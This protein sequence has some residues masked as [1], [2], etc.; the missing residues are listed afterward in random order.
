MGRLA[1]AARRIARAGRGGQRGVRV[2]VTYF[3]RCLAMMRGGGETQHLAWMRA[4]RSLGVEIDIITGRPLLQPPLYP[5]DD[6]PT[7]CCARRTCAIS[8]TKCRAS[9]SSAASAIAWRFT[10]TKSCSDAPGVGADRRGV[11]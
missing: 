4:L 3:M 6:I 11:A 9:A 7:R 5:V 10:P 1:P 2:K 8:S